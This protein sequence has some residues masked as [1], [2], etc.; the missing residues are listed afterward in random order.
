MDVKGLQSL[1]IKTAADGF[2]PRDTVPRQSWG[3]ASQDST[4]TNKY[5]RT[6]PSPLQSVSSPTEMADTVRRSHL[7][8][9]QFVYARYPTAPRMPTLTAEK[10]SHERRARCV[11]PQDMTDLG[12]RSRPRLRASKC[13]RARACRRESPPPA[14]CVLPSFLV[15]SGGTAPRRSLLHPRARLRR[16]RSTRWPWRPAEGA[17]AY[18]MRSSRP[19]RDQCSLRTL[20]CQQTAPHPTKLRCAHRCQ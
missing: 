17:D 9:S 16:Q 3:V 8:L 11:E 18:S 2:S 20:D 1:T 19:Q 10:V 12:Q 7:G 5:E 15:G 14:P 6:H 13:V 4:W